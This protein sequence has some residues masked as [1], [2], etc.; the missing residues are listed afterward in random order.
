MITEIGISIH[1]RYIDFPVVLC[2]YGFLYE[3]FISLSSGV[4]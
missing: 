1:M 3:A 2:L 4:L